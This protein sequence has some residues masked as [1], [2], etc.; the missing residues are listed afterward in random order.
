ML[1]SSKA[2][3]KIEQVTQHFRFQQKKT[4]L[5]LLLEDNSFLRVNK[6]KIW[7]EVLFQVCLRT[8]IIY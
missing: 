2:S 6:K 5:N 4:V 1:Q 3:K 8:V 7:L